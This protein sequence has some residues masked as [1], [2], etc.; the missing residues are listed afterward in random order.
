MGA[1][2]DDLVFDT[3]VVAFFDIVAEAYL[4]GGLFRYGF[5]DTETKL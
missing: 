3:I 4:S 1:E 5:P 2:F